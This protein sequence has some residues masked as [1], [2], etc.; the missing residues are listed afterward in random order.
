MAN[1]SIKE[2]SYFKNFQRFLNE[3]EEEGLIDI[4]AGPAAVLAAAA[5]IPQSILLAGTTDGLPTDEKITI[6]KGSLIAK[7]F[8]P[9]QKN[10]DADKSLADQIYDLHGNLDR[11]IAGGKIKSEQGEFPILTFG[12]N[13]IIDG[14]H[15]WSQA[16]ITN[17]N[18][19]LETADIKAPNVDSP[20]KAIALVHTILFAL[21][22]KSITKD[23][24]G[25]N[26]VGLAPEKVKEMVTTGT[27]LKAGKPIVQSA[28]D[29]LFKAKLI[30]EATAEAAGD[31]YA[32]N[33]TYI[34]E[35]A[36]PR[37]V[38]PQ[39]LDSGS[40]D[41]LTT[42]PGQLGA[43]EI[44]YIAP[45]DSDVKKEAVIKK[46]RKDIL[47]LKEN[48]KREKAILIGE[49]ALKKAKKKK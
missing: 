39:P 2:E 44:N 29:K 7:D 21:Y 12:G 33:V 22:G 6:T 17:P 42:D 43:G 45:K 19:Q 35:G 8:V 47:T 31:M 40:P 11:A 5:K 25:T 30:P 10:I 13:Y 49:S 34:K 20:E 16:C 46:L 1:K 37:A 48:H 3:A 24:Q 15:R 14:H 41:G 38:M 26:L 28:I 27:G 9:T 32:A 23:V 18:G 36:F 4:N